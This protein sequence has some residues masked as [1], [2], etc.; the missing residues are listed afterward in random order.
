MIKVSLRPNLIYPLYLII[1]TF[2]RKIVSI[3]IS[4]L[5]KFNG[6]VIYTFL[7]FL[8]EMVGGFIF[9]R[10]QKE[11][12]NNKIKFELS[13]ESILI[14]RLRKTEMK[15]VDGIP[16]IIFLVFMTSFFDFFEFILSTYYISKIKHKSNTLQIRLGGILIIISSFVCW[17]SLKLS[18]FRHQIF[19]LGVIGIS[20]F[21]LILSEFFFQKYDIIL[22]VRDLFFAIVLSIMSHLSIAF[23]N[24]IEKYLIDF[25][26]L[27]PFLVLTIQG[28]IGFCFTFICAIYENPIPSLKMLYSNNSSGMFILFLFLLLLYTFFGAFKN[29]YRMDTIMLFSPMNKHLADI[30]INPIYIIYYFSV[31]EDFINLGKRNYFYFFINL[32]ILILFDICGLIYNEFLILSC[33]GMDYN[34]YSSIS[35]RAS[36]LEELDAICDDDDK[37]DFEYYIN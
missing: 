15:R 21:F 32:S 3:L 6:S 4:K 16:K 19:S 22:T 14:S 12:G 10:Y 28:I 35:L 1:W 8:G 33:Y 34:T 5:F 2:L 23:N 31:G 26:F 17:V 30:I 37:N 9:Y 18:H 36:K 24:T 13:K 27:H 29:I 7:M 25:N 20:L 11:V